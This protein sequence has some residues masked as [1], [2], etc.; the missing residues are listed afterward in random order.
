MIRKR[1]LNYYD[2]PCGKLKRIY[3]EIIRV[4]MFNNVAS[5]IE[6]IVL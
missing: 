5:Y 2:Y 4:N 3:R 6:M 1:K